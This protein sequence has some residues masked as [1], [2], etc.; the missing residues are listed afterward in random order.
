MQILTTP[1]TCNGM[2]I[3]SRTL[4]PVSILEKLVGLRRKV[5]NNDEAM[6]WHFKTTQLQLFD[7]FGC[8][9]P[10]GYIALDKDKKIKDKGVLRPQKTKFIVCSYWI[11]VLPEVIK[12]LK[13]GDKVEVQYG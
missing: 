10:I 1:I 8:L 9:H 13:L 4:V 6:L 12:N 11:E 2:T 3:A 5:L 7:S